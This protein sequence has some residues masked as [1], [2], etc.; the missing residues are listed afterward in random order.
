MFTFPLI[1]MCLLAFQSDTTIWRYS[2]IRASKVGTRSI[3]GS[4]E[5]KTFE[6]FLFKGALLHPPFA[7]DSPLFPSY[8][9]VPMGKSRDCYNSFDASRFQELKSGLF[10]LFSFVRGCS[11]T[12]LKQVKQHCGHLSLGELICFARTEK[13]CT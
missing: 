4:Y 6:T 3:K 11:Y 2:P 7:S 1:E 8:N 12:E 13:S 9:A 10:F 5:Y